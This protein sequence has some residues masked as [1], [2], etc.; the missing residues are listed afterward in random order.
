MMKVLVLAA[1]LAAIAAS[2]V[3]GVAHAHA[4]DC[5]GTTLKALR[6]CVNSRLDNQLKLERRILSEIKHSPRFAAL[7]VKVAN[8]TRTV[9]SQRNELNSLE[10][11]VGCWGNGLTI[12]GYT[13]IGTATP[14][15]GN[16]DA[17]SYLDR[18]HANNPANNP[19]YK[20]I[21]NQC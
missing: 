11:R 20:I 2:S 13:N 7:S 18:M 3:V 5:R 1:V 9:N 15:N 10:N 16:T 19:I 12:A 6:S 17:S 21:T 14:T 8:L 4:A